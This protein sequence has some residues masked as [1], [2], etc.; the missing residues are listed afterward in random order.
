MEELARES[1]RA[2]L[3]PACEPR[4]HA[5]R[6]DQERGERR[7]RQGHA[8][9]IAVRAPCTPR[10]PDP[11]ADGISARSAVAPSARCGHCCHGARSPSRAPG[12]HELASPAGCL[13]AP[14]AA[15]A[16]EDAMSI[17]ARRELRERYRPRRARGDSRCLPLPLHLR[18]HP[19]RP[20]ADQAPPEN[21]PGAGRSTSQIPPGRRSRPT[22]A[23][24]RRRPRPGQRQAHRRLTSTTPLCSFW[25]AHRE[26]LRGGGGGARPPRS[27]CPG[28][29]RA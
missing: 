25:R 16:H 26:T 29:I 22:A 4:R 3:R 9:W 27:P 28:A 1:R 19:T 11:D 18:D 20:P 10:P 5:I 6:R 8:S 13:R 17:S 21:V 7:D 24:R 2:C 14:R 12:G 15:V 23:R